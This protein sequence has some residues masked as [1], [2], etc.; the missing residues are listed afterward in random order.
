MLP[1]DLDE[2]IRKFA[3]IAR[4]SPPDFQQSCFQTLLKNYL[5][6]NSGHSSCP[7]PDC[8]RAQQAT[9]DPRS[10]SITRLLLR[11]P[12]WCFPVIAC[13]I[14]YREVVRNH[15][16]NLK[17]SIYWSVVCLLLFV[18][19]ESAAFRS[20]W[21]EKY[22]QPDSTTA[23]IEY[24][25]FWL[26]HTLFPKFS[27]V[28]V[29]GDSR[30]AEGFSP[31]AA[32]DATNN[33]LDFTSFGMPGTSPRVWYY[34]LRDADPARN[35]FSAIVIALDHYA[36]TDA[37]EDLADR[38]ADISY[39][40]G[41]LRL[42]DCWEFSGSFTVPDLSHRALTGCLLKGTV[43]RP[44]IL[45][46]LSDIPKRLAEAKD[47][48]NH[49][50]GY[51][52]G[53]GGKPEDLA[54]LSVDLSRAA[55]TFPAGLKDWQINSIKATVLPGPAPQTGNL[56]RYRT[57]WL[58][59]ILDLYKRSPTMVIFVQIP[60]APLPIPLSAIP[61][62]FLNSVRDNP[63]VTILPVD[64]FE[65][66]QHPDIFADGLHLNHVGRQVFSER[67]GRQILAVTRHQ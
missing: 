6:A 41:R 47:F 48:R 34:A 53:Y 10:S 40:A 25:L 64:T 57:R 17:L 54:G 24:R 33:Q 20:G 11:L 36:D 66:L 51:L 12:K 60:R 3:E 29:I 65:D 13:L 27:R 26:N 18:V 39:V 31:R 59:A 22:L 28:L 35:R 44:D 49:G 32:H 21:Y 30:I 61:A 1:P 7:H 19:V 23:Q 45:D 43:M 14:R 62:R 16:L 56:T 8:P 58:G 2:N 46:F 55:L 5:E 63:R 9:A 38:E 4:L 67:L 50:L 52:D 37:S 15:R 42:T